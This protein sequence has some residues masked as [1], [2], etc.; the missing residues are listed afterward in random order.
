MA[1][2]DPKEFPGTEVNTDFTFDDVL[3]WAKA[4]RADESYRYTSPW[5]CAICQFLKET[6][7]CADPSISLNRWR[8]RADPE[9]TPHYFDERVSEAAN[10]ATIENN[11]YDETASFG[12]FVAELEK[13]RVA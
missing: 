5:D 8:S 4:K 1:L 10:W 12:G 3:A 13:R 9:W 11:R 2:Y 7:R 6:G